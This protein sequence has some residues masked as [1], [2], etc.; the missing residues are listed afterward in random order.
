MM[1]KIAD[2]SDFAVA[3]FGSVKAS[4]ILVLKNVLH[5]PKLNATCYLLVSP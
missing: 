1:I 3:C 5:V 4:P 2:A